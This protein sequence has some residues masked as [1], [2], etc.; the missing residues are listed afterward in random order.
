MDGSPG[1]DSCWITGTAGRPIPGAIPCHMPQDAGTSV[2]LAP[3][4]MK[5]R[6]EAL[7]VQEGE[8]F[9]MLVDVDMLLITY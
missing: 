3:C 8:V 7:T 4:E 2:D 1:Q 9:R 5:A 6:A